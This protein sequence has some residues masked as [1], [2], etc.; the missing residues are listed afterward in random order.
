MLLPSSYA[1]SNFLGSLQGLSLVTL[2][3]IRYV[4]ITK[5][6]VDIR[7]AEHLRSGTNRSLLNY[8][9][10]ENAY[11]ISSVQA[12]ILEQNLINHYGL[13][14]NN[15]VLFNKINSI[16]PRYWDKYGITIRF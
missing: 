4:G 1:L 12:H 2:N 7:F 14:K 13:I 15:G 8:T 5:R 10:I 6:N 16:S 11:G 9:P 3:K